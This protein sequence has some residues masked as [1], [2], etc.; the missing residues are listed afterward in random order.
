[1]INYIKT[2]KFIMKLHSVYLIF[3]QNTVMIKIINT[4][5]PLLNNSHIGV[6]CELFLK[7]RIEMLFV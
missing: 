4:D 2:S 3:K 7:N 6:K 1:M 5:I